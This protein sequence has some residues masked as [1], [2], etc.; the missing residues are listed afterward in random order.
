MLKQLFNALKMSS[1]EI[2]SHKDLRP[3]QMQISERGVKRVL[4][5][6]SGFTKPFSSSVED[7]E[8]SC[9][10]SG[11]PAKPDIAEDLWLKTLAG[12]IWK[13]SSTRV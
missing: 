9:W 8:L 12:R 2:S 4:E 6:I 11:V 7:N 5:A 1:D 10:S 13:T 3:A